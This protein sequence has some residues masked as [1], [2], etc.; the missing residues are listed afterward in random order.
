MD[1]P[2]ASALPLAAAQ[3]APATSTSFGDGTHFVGENGVLPGIY[4]VVEPGIHY[5]A[6]RLRH[7]SGQNAILANWSGVTPG[8]IEILPT[9]AGV[10][11]RGG[12][13]WQ[14]VSQ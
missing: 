1:Q 7:F 14:R 11:S 12:V 4:Q 8:I 9:D 6:A 2:S 5:Y 3:P 10:E 13:T